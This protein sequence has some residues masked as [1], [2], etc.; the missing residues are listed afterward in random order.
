[1]VEVFHRLFC[2]LDLLRIGC[3][4][5]FTELNRNIQ[6]LLDIVCP[7]CHRIGTLSLVYADLPFGNL[8]V[9]WE[10]KQET[11]CQSIGFVLLLEDL[12]KDVGLNATNQVDTRMANTHG[13]GF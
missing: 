4:T 8:L 13:K 1:M 6:D 10:Y 12:V 5:V 11:V 7:G 3:Y 2:H 9:L